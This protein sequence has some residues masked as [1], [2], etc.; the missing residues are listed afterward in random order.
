M[1]NKTQYL[2]RRGTRWYYLRRV[3]KDLLRLD[4][5][6]R[7]RVALKTD[8]LIVARRR[9]DAL[10]EADD[11]Y[12]NSL[13]AELTTECP[14]EDTL[15]VIARARYQAARSRALAQGFSYMPVEELVVTAPIEDLVKRVLMVAQNK[16]NPAV[17][18]ESVLGGADLPDIKLSE[19]FELYCDRLAIG[20]VANKSPAQIAA[21]R[22]S[23]YRAITN[24]VS[25]VGDMSMTKLDRSHARQFYDWWADRLR[26]KGN[27]KP[28][29]P[30]SANRDLGTL[31]KLYREYWEYEGQEERDNPFRK[32]RFKDVVMSETPP[33]DD[34]WVQTKILKPGVFTKGN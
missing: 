15:A 5:R 4:P 10:A 24:F 27:C 3:P 23:K 13:R 29:K 18:V 33:F 6:M 7:V 19:A 20:D 1:A 28:L 25:V 12:W 34:K 30:N 2:E 31:R 8:S 9:R 16:I 26:P 14:G 32:L 21:W 22:K 11:Y 17:Q